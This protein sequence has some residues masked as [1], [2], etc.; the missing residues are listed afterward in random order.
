MN[1]DIDFEVLEQTQMSADDFLYLYIIHKESYTYLNN[2]NLKPNLEKLQEDGYIKLGETPDQHFIRQEFIDLFS[3]NFDQMFAELISTYPMKVMT[4]DRGIRMLHAK[5]P[6]ALNNKKA[7]DKYEKIVGDKLYKHKHIMK[8]LNTEL[9]INRFN[10]SYMQ[11]LQTWI[12][13]HTWEKYENLDEHD[14]KQE[15][16]RITRS[17]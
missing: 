6:D 4:P 16:N 11:N 9:T 13:N 2:L 7:K 14:T 17:L 8:C 15:T 1:V 10:L 3:S 5:D 12:N